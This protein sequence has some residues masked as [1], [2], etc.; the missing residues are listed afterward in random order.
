MLVRVCAHRLHSD[1]ALNVI[2]KSYLPIKIVGTR[3]DLATRVVKDLKGGCTSCELK[4]LRALLPQAVGDPPDDYKYMDFLKEFGEAMQA[5]A[6][7]DG[8]GGEEDKAAVVAEFEAYKKHV[9]RFKKEKSNEMKDASKPAR[10]QTCRTPDNCT[11]FSPNQ[12]KQS[13]KSNWLL[14]KVPGVPD[15]LIQTGDRLKE[16][17]KI[18]RA[19]CT[20]SDLKELRSKLPLDALAGPTPDDYEFKDF[21]RDL[22]ESMQVI[23]APAVD[24]GGGG[25]EGGDVTISA[26]MTCTVAFRATD[27]DDVSFHTKST[28]ERVNRDYD[29][30]GKSFIASYDIKYD[31]GATEEGVNKHRVF[32]YSSKRTRDDDDNLEDVEFLP[33]ID[34]PL[35]DPLEVCVQ[36][37]CDVPESAHVTKITALLHSQGTSPLGRQKSGQNVYLVKTS[38]GAK[39]IIVKSTAFKP[40]AQKYYSNFIGKLPRAVSDAGVS[41]FMYCMDDKPCYAEQQ[42]SGEWKWSK[43]MCTEQ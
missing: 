19:G 21:K 3:D 8:D 30:N 15:D 35:K 25:G 14:V 37:A 4:E 36:P 41:G 20:S 40:V 9:F 28:I 12:E 2:S 27:G 29:R 17:E 24:G 42:E 1:R 33:L 11:R 22:E 18:I 16:A 31:D 7:G 23:R 6:Q 5:R 10:P 39:R 26:G 43:Q 32:G 38:D 34:K 13:R